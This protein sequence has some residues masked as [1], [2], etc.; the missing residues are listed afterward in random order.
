[1]IYAVVASTLA[2]DI[3]CSTFWEQSRTMQ[4]VSVSMTQEFYKNFFDMNHCNYIPINVFI[5]DDGTA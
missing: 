4:R 1:M 2:E 5:L 3:V